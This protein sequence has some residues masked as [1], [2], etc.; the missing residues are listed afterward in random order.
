MIQPLY[1]MSAVGVLE[2]KRLFLEPLKLSYLSQVYVNWLNDDVVNQYMTSGGD[3]TLE[4]LKQYLE[5]VELNPKYF[6]AI[7]LKK[8][9][10]HIGNIKIDPIDLN[11]LYG[12]YGIMI[13]DRRAWGKGIAK[14]ASEIVLTFCFETLQLK[15]INLGVHKNNLKA[16]GLYEKLGFTF[17]KQSESNKIINPHHRMFLHNPNTE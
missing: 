15:K 16:I 7:K 17:E 10:K 3:Y 1:S 9:N 8:T 6:W 14:E 4:K 13:G 2:T 5:E 11:S 12:E